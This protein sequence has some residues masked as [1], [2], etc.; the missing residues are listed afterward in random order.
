MGKLVVEMFYSS[1]RKIIEIPSPLKWPSGPGGKRGVYKGI[2]SQDEVLPNIWPL[3]L[4]YVI[5]RIVPRNDTTYS[6]GSEDSLN[7]QLQVF[8]IQTKFQNSKSAAFVVV[9]V[10][11][12]DFILCMVRAFMEAMN[13]Q[14]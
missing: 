13:K 11:L 5:N 1:Y 10:G 14:Q 4:A 8:G 9:A 3:L 7:P 6:T 2:C 12:L